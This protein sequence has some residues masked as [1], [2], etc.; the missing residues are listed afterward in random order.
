MPLI[1]EHVEIISNILDI[2]KQETLDDLFSIDHVNEMS[3]IF[4]YYVDKNESPIDYTPTW[5]ESSE[6]EKRNI[7]CNLLYLI[8][9]IHEG[10]I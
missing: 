3:K 1:K 10:N 7:F 8:M 5:N 6:Q 9:D 2:D 4:Q